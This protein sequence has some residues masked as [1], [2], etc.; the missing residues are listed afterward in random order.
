M[1]VW[2]LFNEADDEC[3]FEKLVYG[4]FDAQNFVFFLHASDA[5]AAMQPHHRLTIKV[6]CWTAYCTVRS[7]NE[8]HVV[9]VVVTV[10]NYY[11]F[12]FDRIVSN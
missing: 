8:A 4:L 11:I 2:F 9:V 1:W 6:T 5:D 12:Q 3:F 7:Q 10:K